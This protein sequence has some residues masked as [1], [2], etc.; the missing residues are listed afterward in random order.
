MEEI[1]AFAELLKAAHEGNDPSGG[2][3]PR[4]SRE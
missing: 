1:T 3:V 2:A 4:F